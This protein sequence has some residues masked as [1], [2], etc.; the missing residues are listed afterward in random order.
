MRIDPDHDMSI[1]VFDSHNVD[2]KSMGRPLQLLHLHCGFIEGGLV[3]S[4]TGMLGYNGT[5]DLIIN[6]NVTRLGNDI[7]FQNK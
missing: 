2:F 4:E 3:V 6:N 7:N 1:N 5:A